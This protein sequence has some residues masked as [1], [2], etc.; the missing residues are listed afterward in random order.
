MFFDQQKFGLE[1]KLSLLIQIQLMEYL[2]YVYY[3][4]MQKLEH[5]LNIRMLNLVLKQINHLYL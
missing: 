5:F 2:M 1:L 4:K 3:Q